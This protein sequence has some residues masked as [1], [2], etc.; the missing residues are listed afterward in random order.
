[1]NEEDHGGTN[2]RGTGG[3]TAG[4]DGRPFEERAIEDRLR[5]AMVAAI[6]VADDEAGAPAPDAADLARRRRARARRSRTVLAV[7]AVVAVLAASGA[8][9]AIGR[10]GNTAKL[11][12]SSDQVA[13]R[14][15]VPAGPE[16]PETGVSVVADPDLPVVAPS[17]HRVR[18]G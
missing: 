18:G 2:P 4:A 14:P 7:A 3:R 11:G 5:V 1:M 13:G 8:G 9:W 15:E 12:D 17:D 6:E 10:T 16:A